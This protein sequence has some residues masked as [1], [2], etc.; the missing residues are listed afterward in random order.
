MGSSRSPNS[1][2][3]SPAAPSSRNRFISAMPS[4]ICWPPGEKS[5]FWA[6]GIRS[7]RKMSASSSRA[8][9]CRRFTHGPRLVDTVTSGEVVTIRSARSLSVRAIASRTLPKAAWVEIDCLRRRARRRYFPA[10]RSVAPEAAAA[11][12]EERR[13]REEAPDLCLS[14]CRAPRTD[15]I[16]ALRVSASAPGTPPSA[17]PSSARRDCPCDPRAACPSPLPYRR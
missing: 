11:F 5:H 8:N 1:E 12:G 4:S 13:L 14:A 6:L 16:R 3:D 7:A 10:Q 17:L 2:W 9:N 15:P